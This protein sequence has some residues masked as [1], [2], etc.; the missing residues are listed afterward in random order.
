VDQST[1]ISQIKVVEERLN[2]TLFKK[3]TLPIYPTPRGK[4]VIEKARFILEEVDNL[5]RPFK[6]GNLRVIQGDLHST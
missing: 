5:I 3:K 6:E 4:I 1:L 2:N